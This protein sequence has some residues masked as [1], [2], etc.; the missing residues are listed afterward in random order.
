MGCFLGD[1]SG[2][3]NE[4]SKPE[5]RNFREPVLRCV[6]KALWVREASTDTHT[7]TAL[8]ALVRQ[9]FLLAFWH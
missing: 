4:W 1:E 7:H 2:W 5:C 6:F 3:L 8:N 9:L